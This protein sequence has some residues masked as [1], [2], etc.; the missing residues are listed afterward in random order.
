MQLKELF[1][2]PEL[3]GVENDLQSTLSFIIHVLN[4]PNLLCTHWETAPAG[5]WKF[6]SLY[7]LRL[8]KTATDLI[9]SFVTP[10]NSLALGLRRSYGF[11][12]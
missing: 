12:E 2:N 9:H 8:L 3:T 7:N 6:L 1:E 4:I 5:E 11:K 10:L